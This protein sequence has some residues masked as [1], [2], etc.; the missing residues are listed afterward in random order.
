[1]VDITT[2]DNWQTIVAANPAGTTYTI[3]A[4]THVRPGP[5]TSIGDGDTFNFENGAIADGSEAVDSWVDNGDGTWYS[6][7]HTTGPTTDT[8]TYLNNANIDS[9][10]NNKQED[11]FM[12]GEPMWQVATSGELGNYTTPSGYDMGPTWW[13]DGTNDRIYISVDPTGHEF[14]L[15][16]VKIL[17]DL[18]NSGA[19][20]VT[21]AGPAISGGGAHGWPSNMPLLRYFATYVQ[22]GLIDAGLG[23][24]PPAQSNIV[25]ENLRFYGN[26]GGTIRAGKD[27]GRIERC[28]FEYM[29]QI[30]IVANNWHGGVLR[31]C[32]FQQHAYN[33]IESG[34]EGGCIK[35][36][37]SDDVIMEGN[38]VGFG[39]GYGLWSDIDNFRH[40]IRHNI[41]EDCGRP[42]ITYEISYGD[43]RRARVHNNYVRNCGW[44]ATAVWPWGAQI[45]VQNSPEVHVFANVVEFDGSTATGI[46]SGSGSHQDGIGQVN[47]TRSGFGQ[48]LGNLYDRNIVVCQAGGAFA[49]EVVGFSDDTGGQ[50]SLQSDNGTELDENTYHV[51]STGLARYRHGGSTYTFTNWKSQ[52]PGYDANSSETATA[53]SR[54]PVLVT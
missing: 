29:G 3:K 42:G 13:F 11:L 27:A 53:Y 36:S 41:V 39:Y 25:V 9:R 15:S 35:V 4:G 2:S 24:N 19:S 17:F 45:L 34:W 40:Q 51:P 10:G 6:T 23:S 49:G 7:G 46:S 38:R 26:H 54:T 12:D 8:G 47:Q 48:A 18:A 31:N 30:G 52:G 43:E 44:D 33:L 20:N 16:V 50:D 32:E 5:V 14:R 22:G 28:L 21:I 37:E 1:M